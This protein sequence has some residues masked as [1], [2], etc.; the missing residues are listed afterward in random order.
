MKRRTVIKL[1]DRLFSRKTTVGAPNQRRRSFVEWFPASALV[2]TRHESGGPAS[3]MH[4]SKE[5]FMA[6]R[7]PIAF[8]AATI[9]ISCISATDAS[10]TCKFKAKK[11]FIVIVDVGH[12][13]KDS[14]QISARG[15]KEYDLNLKLAGRVLE[16]LVNTGFV[17]TQMIVTSGR[18]THAS[19]LQRS[20][21]ANDLGADLFISVHHDGVKNETLMP[22]QYN[23]KT[24]WFLD[25]FEGFSLWVSQ[26]NNKYK[27]SLGFA[28][29]LADQ[30]MASGL[31]FT[32]HHDELTNSAKYGR[33]AP[34]V[35]RERGIYDASDHIAV[36]YESHM[37]AV[38]VEAGMIV[39]RAEEQ[40]LSSATRRTSVARAVA[41]AV[42]RFCAGRS[43]T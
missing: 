42:E 35:D 21:R 29:T 14:G 33:I 26:K 37:P 16:E 2:Q 23:G 15:I 40:V 38:L 18:N 31:K 36:L 10:A 39:N 5:K 28:K 22:W 9:G 25:K 4:T 13:D 30:L 34:L 12:S 24:H 8:A 11:D 19:R 6:C 3:P 17:S 32:T 43:Q 41:T 20:K 1:L 27:E 7:L